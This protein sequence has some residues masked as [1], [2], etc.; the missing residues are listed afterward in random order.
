MKN[1]ASILI[2]NSF[3]LSLIRRPVRIDPQ[4]VEALHR[5]AAGCHVRSFWGHGNTRALAEAFIDLSLKTQTERPALGLQTDGRP[6]LD[7]Q[8]FG[9]C[10]VLSPNYAE[11]FRPAVGAEIAPA[12]IR[13]WQILKLT[14]E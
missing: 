4:T 10:W 1:K 11:H 9:E 2:G 14:W 13:G 8:T 12:S 6:T 7:G 3:P 5:A